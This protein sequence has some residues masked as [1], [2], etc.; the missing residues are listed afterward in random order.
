MQEGSFRCDANVSVRR[1]GSDG[2]G[3]RTELKNL[4]SFRFVERAINY[5]IRRQIERLED[6]RTITQETRLY[7][8]EEDETRPLRGKEEAH[9]YRYFPDP[10]LLP[11]ELSQAYVDEVRA[12]LPEL[13]DAKRLRFRREYGLGPEDADDLSA[14]REVADY[15]DSTVRAAAGSAKACANWI[16]GELMAAL[17][18][19]GWDI[20]RSPVTPAMLGAMIKRVAD[21]TISGRSAKEVFQAMWDGA[22]EADHIIASRR[23]RQLTDDATIEGLV[24]EVIASN[25]EQAAQYRAGKSKVLGFLVGKVMKLSHGSADPKQVNELLR[26]QL[27]GGSPN[28]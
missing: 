15:F 12:G 18:R 27:R 26:N 13:P 3:T 20:S 16:M 28:P 1:L 24:A 5:E 2:L 10:D 8:P 21:G 7:D 23:L 19:N 14:S 17:H 9:D 4:N 22:G 11:L 25:P 6:G